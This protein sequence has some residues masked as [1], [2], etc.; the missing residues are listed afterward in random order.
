MK[1]AFLVFLTLLAAPAGAHA[2]IFS[3]FTDMAIEGVAGYV[4]AGV[5]FI[6]SV[7]LGSYVNKYKKAVQEL[8]DVL[9][10]ISAGMKEDSPGGKKYTQEEVQ[11]ILKE[12]GEFGIEAAAIYKDKI[13][14][15]RPNP[16]T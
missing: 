9:F 14:G 12:I 1:K 2:G 11:T 13:S 16:T 10:A 5:F 6:L 8:K 4:I 7:V 15:A 3:R